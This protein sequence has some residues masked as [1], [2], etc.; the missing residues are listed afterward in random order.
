M[1]ELIQFDPLALIILLIAGG[2]VIYV[3][4]IFTQAQTIRDREMWTALQS[5]MNNV[6]AINNNWL[7]T[8]Q[9]QGEKSSEA[10]QSLSGDIAANTIQMAE[11]TAA[12]NRSI[13]SGASLH[14]ATDL[15]V[16]VLK[17][18][19]AGEAHKK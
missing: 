11:L 4:R 15:L 19:A 7:V 14:G 1:S 9:S 2:G 13:E 5:M 16:T 17:N 3:V 12:I 8:F 10:I 6:I 18:G